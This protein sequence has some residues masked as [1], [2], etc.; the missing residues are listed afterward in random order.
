MRRQ[1][2]TAGFSAISA[3]AVSACYFSVADVEERSGGCSPAC[4]GNEE[5]VSGS[6]QPLCS[7]GIRCGDECV[8]QLIDPRHCGQCG[9]ACDSTKACDQGTCSSSCS[10]GTTPCAGSCVN[11]QTNPSHC[12]ACDKSCQAGQDCAGGSCVKACAE[13]LVSGFTDGWGAHWDGADRT[14]EAF[15][16][17]KATCEGLAGR[18]PS[19]TELYRVRAGQATALPQPSAND[20]WALTPASAGSRVTLKLDDGTTQTGLT[21]ETRAF[22]CTCPA[23][24]PPG[25]SGS[26]CHSA[27]PGKCHVLPGAV[28]ENVD[29]L[30]RPALNRGR[31]NLG[32]WIQRWPASYLAG[33]RPRYS[34]RVGCW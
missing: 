33:L 16:A 34:E 15:A 11:V 5:C 19:A 17:A 30:D 28:A 9:N 12:G 6:C 18:L 29:R 22:R 24:P 10:R 4:S 23:T 8:N 3:V 26:M 1:L 27:E 31:S 14:P 32:V 7:S 25:F 20:L 2:W 13:Q 21:T